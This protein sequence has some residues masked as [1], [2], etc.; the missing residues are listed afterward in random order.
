MKKTLC[1]L[2]ERQSYERERS[3]VIR[4]HMKTFSSV[5]NYA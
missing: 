3:I 5:D 2:S 1:I 4:E